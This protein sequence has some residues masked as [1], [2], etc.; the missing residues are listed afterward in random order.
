MLYRSQEH[1]L[2]SLT[3]CWLLSHRLQSKPH[4]A[5]NS[6]ERSCAITFFC[7]I[8][9]FI[10]LFEQSKKSRSKAHLNTISHY[11]NVYARVTLQLMF[12]PIRSDARHNDYGEDGDK[13]FDLVKNSQ[14]CLFVVS[15]GNFNKMEL[16]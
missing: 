10:Y 1:I 14:F 2:L 15:M 3:D 6:A 5:A 4:A 12:R 7:C 8:H 13:P 9:L 11:H 16:K